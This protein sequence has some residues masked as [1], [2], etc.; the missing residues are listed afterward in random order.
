MFLFYNALKRCSFPQIKA[1]NKRVNFW[2]RIR[3][4][5]GIGCLALFRPWMFVL[6]AGNIPQKNKSASPNKRISRL[7]FLSSMKKPD[8]SWWGWVEVAVIKFHLLHWRKLCGLIIRTPWPITNIA[9]SR[10][11]RLESGD[12]SAHLFMLLAMLMLPP[13]WSFIPPLLSFLLLLS[14]PEKSAQDFTLICSSYVICSL[15]KRNTCS[16]IHRTYFLLSSV[17][18]EITRGYMKNRVN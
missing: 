7:P 13:R 18:T 6:I 2:N 10:R 3:R 11:W 12:N 14:W 8:M 4:H 9:F 5:I 1:Y 16:Q 15:Q 17:L